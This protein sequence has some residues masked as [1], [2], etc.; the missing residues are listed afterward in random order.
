LTPVISAGSNVPGEYVAPICRAE[1]LVPR[2][3]LVN[4]FYS[5]AG[6]NTLCLRNSIFSCKKLTNPWNAQD[7]GSMFFP[8]YQCLPIVLNCVKIH[9]NTIWK[10]LAV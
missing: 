4:W 5:S 9:K 6:G 7:R 2:F 8:K 10:I 1:G 3:N